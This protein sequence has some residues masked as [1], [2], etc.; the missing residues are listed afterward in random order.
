MGDDLPDLSAIIQCRLGT[1][2]A[3]GH[4]IVKQHADW[5]SNK[6]GGNGAVRELADLLLQANDLFDASVKSFF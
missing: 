1:T 3:N 4:D 5:V 6:S 2:V